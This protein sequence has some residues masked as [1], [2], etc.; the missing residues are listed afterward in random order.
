MNSS[1]SW[2]RRTRSGPYVAPL[3]LSTAGNRLQ[4]NPT[5]QRERPGVD[6]LEVELDPALETRGCCGPAPATG[7]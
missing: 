4:Q 6:V 7:R 2:I 5:I 1:P 3:P